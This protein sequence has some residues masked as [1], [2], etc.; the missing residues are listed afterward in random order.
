[1]VTIL[2]LGIVVA[3]LIILYFAYFLKSELAKLI[4]FILLGAI[5]VSDF[6]GILAGIDLLDFLRDA[7]NLLKTFVIFIELALIVF[8]VFFKMKTKSS[9]VLK[10][11]AVVLLVLLLLVEFNIFS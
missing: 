2:H 5:L 1:M 11:T 9:S 3:S 10:I 6:L 8:L 7:F 4:V